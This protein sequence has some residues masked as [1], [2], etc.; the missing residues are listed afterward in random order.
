MANV[1]ELRRLLSENKASWMI[2]N[3]TGATLSQTSRANTIWVHWFRQGHPR[4][5]CRA[6]EATSHSVSIRR[7]RE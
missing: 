4:R 5:G 3:G 7:D 2:G 1:D 6:S